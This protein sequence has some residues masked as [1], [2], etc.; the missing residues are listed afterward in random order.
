MTCPTFRDFRNVGTR[1]TPLSV[2]AV[3]SVP[4]SAQPSCVQV[5]PSSAPLSSRR[6]YGQPVLAYAPNFSPAVPGICATLLSV[7]HASTRVIQHVNAA[8]TVC[9]AVNSDPCDNPAL[10]ANAR[11]ARLYPSSAAAASLRIVVLWTSQWQLPAWWSG[12]HV[13]LRERG[14]SLPAQIR[15]LA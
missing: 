4:P 2:P 1:A 9:A 3:A 15:R 7:A 6:A 12:R 14:A 13:C 5:L 8:P 10:L 11:A